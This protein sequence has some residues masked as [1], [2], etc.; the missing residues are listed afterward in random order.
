MRDQNDLLVIATTD[1]ER[2]AN[3][4]PIGFKLVNPIGRHRS[5]S[6]PDH[7]ANPESIWGIQFL[8]SV[9]LQSVSQ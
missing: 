2:R 3:E 9:I 8:S 6:I 5:I 7:H 4:L 1:V